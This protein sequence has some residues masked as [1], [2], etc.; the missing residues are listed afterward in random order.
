MQEVP[1][2]HLETATASHPSFDEFSRRYKVLL[3]ATDLAARRGFPDLL[4]ELSQLLRE[5]FDFNFLNYAIRDELSD[6]MQV[7]MVDENLHAPDPVEFSTCESPAGWVW[8]Q[9]QRLVI[10]DS[11]FDGRFRPVLDL[12]AS[13]GFHSLVVLPITTARRRLGT[14]CFGSTKP[15]HYDDEV[16][17]FLERLASLVG[18][19]LENSLSLDVP[20]IKQA[21]ISEEE[22]L[23]DLAAIRLQLSERNAAAHE[24]LRREQ[25]QLE[26]VLEIQSALA[27]SRL[28]L[29][30]MF[31]SITAPVR[32]ANQDA[33]DLHSASRTEDGCPETLPELSRQEGD[34]EVFLANEHPRREAHVEVERLQTLLEISRALTLSSDSR[35]L[36]RDMSASLRRLIAQDYTDLAFWDASTDTMQIHALDFPEGRGLITSE[37]RTR[38]LECP[39]GIAFRAQQTRIFHRGEL[40]R[41]GSDFAK[42]LLAEG[43]SSVCSLPLNS[44]GRILGTLD[45]ARKKE[46]GFAD[47]EIELLKQIAPQVAMAVDNFRVFDEIASLKQKL[48]NENIRLK[49]ETRP[50]FDLSEIVGQSVGLASVL[51]QAKTVAPSDAT[52]LILGE[53]GTGKELIARA[54]HKLSPRSGANFV[55]LNCAAIPTGLLESELFGHEKGAFTSAVSQKVGRL[56]LADKGT[57]FLD[58]VGEIPLELQPKLLRVLQDQEF[59][60][61]G[62]TRTIRVN[63]RVLAATNRDVSKAVANH[64]FRSDLYYRLHVFPV[65]LPALRERREDIP[66][67]VHHFVQKFARRM[68]KKVETIP[69]EA[70]WAL[71]KWDWPGNIREL[72]NFMERSVILTEGVTLRVPVGE[73]VAT[74]EGSASGYAPTEPEM[75][76]SQGTLEELERQ[77]IVQVL[78]QAGGIVSGSRGAAARL[79]MKRTT[80]QSKMQRLGISREEYAS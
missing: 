68:N 1:D 80:L 50:A 66:I 4:Q 59:E 13:R 25:E 51:Q 18:L 48:S 7:R 54:I 30:Q 10:S 76:G 55:K 16:L 74:S 52:V 56:E 72:E 63:V 17:Y 41:I 33:R 69:A 12:Y 79:G 23:R 20:V 6:L 53:T 57:L 43:I 46:S 36:V 29:R 32:S 24:A 31:P 67:L 34:A 58:E 22:Q 15:T 35:A 75:L 37:T 27:A 2:R 61:L 40:E 3:H 45:V 8:S 28:D 64:E 73:L 5:L 65:R 19:A 26:T 38:I 39:A 70:M 14:I 60:R 62:G 78:R 21:L 71:E 9:Q 44:R 11:Q 49:P 42:N 77:Y 47:T